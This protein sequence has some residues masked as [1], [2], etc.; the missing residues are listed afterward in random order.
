MYKNLF[1]QIG[2]IHLDFLV[3]FGLVFLVHVFIFY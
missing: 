3:N 2:I 1:I